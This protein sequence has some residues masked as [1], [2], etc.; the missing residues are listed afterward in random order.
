[1]MER[2]RGSIVNL[3]SI[4]G[5]DGNIG[6]S[7]YAAA[8]GGVIA[9][10]RSWAKEFA[11]KGAQVRV[12]AVAP[13]FIRTPMTEKVPAKILDSIVTRVPL[14]RLGEPG[15]VANLVAFLAGDESAYIT[16]QVIRVDG[17]LV[18]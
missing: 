5:L 14:G 12:N 3:A 6:Q 7:N 13:G 10:T 18:L 11:R 15:D 4:V 8:K 1:M 16:G 17:G 2:G 9:L